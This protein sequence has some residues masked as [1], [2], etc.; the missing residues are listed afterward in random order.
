MAHAPE[1][2]GWRRFKSAA[3]GAGRVVEADGRHRRRNGRPLANALSF[4]G[5]ETWTLATR[6]TAVPEA[7]PWDYRRIVEAS[8]ANFAECPICGKGG[9]LTAEHVPPARLGGAVL[10][11]TCRACNNVFG[12]YEEALLQH[13]EQRYTMAIRGP[14]IAG[15]RRVADVILRMTP[16]RELVMTTWN[17]FWPDWTGPL[18]TDVGV[19]I[20]LERRCS[21]LAYAAMLKNGLLAACALNPMIVTDPSSWPVAQMVRQQLV[22]WRTP[23]ESHLEIDPRLKRLQVRYDAPIGASPGVV[24]CEATNRATGQRAHVI[25]LGWQLAIEWPVD[26]AR[27][28][29]HT[30]P[31]S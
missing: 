8:R 7:D 24:L 9:P 1:V 25:R 15:E 29:Q 20:Q 19:E 30:T 11:E 3:A 10:T 2:T 6:L 21:C 23:S 16:D 17:G 14:G 28:I 5:E 12:S 22:A 13:A 4:E 27:L 31:A 26:A 18:F